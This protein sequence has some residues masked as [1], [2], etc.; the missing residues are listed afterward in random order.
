M[1]QKLSDSK[2]DEINELFT[3]LEQT[4]QINSKQSEKIHQLEQELN[5]HQSLEQES[6]EL[7][8]SIKELEEQ[9]KILKKNEINIQNINNN[10]EFK[11]EELESQCQELKI[12]INQFESE[13]LNLVT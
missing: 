2:D 4:N 3:K 11:I 7:K 10:N 13:K 9:I 1:S 12:K 5:E 6:L 8:N